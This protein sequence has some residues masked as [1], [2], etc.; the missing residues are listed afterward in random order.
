MSFLDNQE[1]R[2]R[3]DVEMDLVA[4]NLLFLTDR[5]DVKPMG[6]RSLV[7]PDQH[8]DLVLGSGKFAKAVYKEN[9]RGC[10]IMRT[11]LRTPGMTVATEPVAFD[12]EGDD[13]WAFQSGISTSS[14]L[15]VNWILTQRMRKREVSY[16]S[17]T[18]VLTSE[19]QEKQLSSFIGEGIEGQCY[20]T[21]SYFAQDVCT[22]LAQWWTADQE[23]D[24]D[25]DGAEV[26][27]DAV[28]TNRQ[29]SSIKIGIEFKNPQSRSNTLK[30]LTQAS[31]YRKAH[32]EGYG[33][34]PIAYCCPGKVPTGNEADYVL[35]RLRVGLLDFHDS[36]LLRLR[37]FS[38][39]EHTG[40]L[41]KEVTV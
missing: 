22:Y 23:V 26:R 15:M 13:P 18:G 5:Y 31:K 29:D 41:T 24:G 33:R 1:P 14:D 28:L 6:A 21:E 10:Q 16:D 39:S 3:L 17:A 19:E 36:W 9:L 12:V 35:H 2:R 7:I 27:I 20:P 32:W 34:L 38:W 4:L 25:L 40:L 37:E 30:G 8:S 11:R